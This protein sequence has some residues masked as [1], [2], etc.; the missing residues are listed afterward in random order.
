MVDVGGW[1]ACVGVV[2]TR[3]AATD[4]WSSLGSP[5]LSLDFSCYPDSIGT[6]Q[7]LSVFARKMSAPPRPSP[8]PLHADNSGV[9]PARRHLAAVSGALPAPLPAA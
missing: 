6:R 3:S 4:T 5:S 8:R 9:E 2:R 1:S 7:E